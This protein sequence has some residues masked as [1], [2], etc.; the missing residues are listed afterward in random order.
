MSQ[1]MT[2]P[3]KPCR[4]FHPVPLSFHINSKLGLFSQAR[5]LSGP[6]GHSPALTAGLASSK[7]HAE[8]DSLLY[9]ITKNGSWM[10]CTKRPMRENTQLQVRIVSVAKW[11]HQFQRKI[12]CASVHCVSQEQEAT[13]LFPKATNFKVRKLNNQVNEDFW[14]EL[15][16]RKCDKSVDKTVT[17]KPKLKRGP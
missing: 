15:K 4:V 9:S 14:F 1:R 10:H 16:N 7:Y 13:K 2:S 8:S 3:T 11:T 6:L 17:S 12:L 5:V